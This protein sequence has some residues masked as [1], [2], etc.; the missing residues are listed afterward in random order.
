MPF[1]PTSFSPFELRLYRFNT[2]SL[3]LFSTSYVLKA[4]LLQYKGS[5]FTI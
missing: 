2:T 1:S 5:A 4:V 3:L